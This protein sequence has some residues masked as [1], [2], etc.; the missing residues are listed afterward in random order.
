MQLST[1]CSALLHEYA[2]EYLF[3]GSFFPPTL[4][5]T[6]IVRTFAPN[7]KRVL[8]TPNRVIAVVPDESAVRLEILGTDNKKLIRVEAVAVTKELAQKVVLYH[9]AATE[10]VLAQYPGLDPIVQVVTGDDSQAEELKDEQQRQLLQDA[11]S[12]AGAANSKPLMRLWTRKSISEKCLPRLSQTVER[13]VKISLQLRFVD[14]SWSDP[15]STRTGAKMPSIDKVRTKWFLRPVDGKPVLKS[16]RARDGQTMIEIRD[17]P[18]TPVLKSCELRVT[19]KRCG[20]LLSHTVLGHGS[21]R[22]DGIIP[23]DSLG[24]FQVADVKIPLTSSS[25]ETEIVGQLKCNVACI[26]NR[27]TADAA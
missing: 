13:P 21:L 26:A 8:T 22:L 15:T 27:K 3:Y 12:E 19:V 14:L 20:S 17:V 7:A 9:C 11:V 18:A 2:W 6:V 24:I 4:F 23:D 5:E 1:K 10:S 16:V 25:H